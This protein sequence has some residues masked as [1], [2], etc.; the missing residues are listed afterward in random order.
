VGD[1]QTPVN[2]NDWIY[3]PSVMASYTLNKHLSAELNY[4][5]DLVQSKVSTS[6]EGATWADG[7]EFTRNLVS[8]AVKY[9][10]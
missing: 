1:W 5:C 7:R 10:F 6:A 8:L 3:T 9:V 2:R 4:S